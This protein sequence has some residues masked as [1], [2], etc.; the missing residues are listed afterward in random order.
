MQRRTSP[1]PVTKFSPTLRISQP[2]MNFD[3]SVAYSKRDDGAVSPTSEP[4]AIN[5][6]AF[7]K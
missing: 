3:H 4:R 2:H 6:S 1:R 5:A 7:Y